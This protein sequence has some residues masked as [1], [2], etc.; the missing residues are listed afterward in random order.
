[1]VNRN[2][3]TSKFHDMKVGLG[4]TRRQNSTL[5]Q[6]IDSSFLPEKFNLTKNMKPK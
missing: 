4:W 2:R 6:Q 3:E 5:K 1:M